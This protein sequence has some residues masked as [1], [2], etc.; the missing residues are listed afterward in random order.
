MDQLIELGKAKEVQDVDLSSFQKSTWHMPSELEQTPRSVHPT[1][2]SRMR[3]VFIPILL[4]FSA[5]AMFSILPFVEI[6]NKQILLLAL[7][8]QLLVSIG[9]ALYLWTL[10]NREREMLESASSVKGLVGDVKTVR[11]KR[12]YCDNFSVIYQVDNVFYR[13]SC[14]GPKDQ[15]QP[16]QM[17]TVLFDQLNPSRALVYPSSRWTIDRLAS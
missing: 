13:L 16:G 15:F 7:G 11:A 3:G 14:S 8:V 6:E 10:V 5:L 1:I 17:V 12:G 4:V 9:L 2:H